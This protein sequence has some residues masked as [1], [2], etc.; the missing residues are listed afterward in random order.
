MAQL[1]L[2]VA[3]GLDGGAATLLAVLADNIPASPQGEGQ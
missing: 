3:C 2:Q 1:G